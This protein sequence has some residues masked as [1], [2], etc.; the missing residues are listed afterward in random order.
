M[1]PYAVTTRTRA[2]ATKTVRLLTIS[3]A[4]AAALMVSG[5]ASSKRSVGTHG[6]A[7]A[8]YYA[9]G[10][11]DARRAVDYWGRAYESNPK[12]REAVLNYA[13][14][15][16]R[17]DQLPQ[18]EAVLRKAVINDGRDRDIASAYGKTLA[19][20]GKLDESLQ[21]IRGAQSPTRPDWRLMSAEAAVID[22]M[23]DGQTA[24][25]LYAQALKIAPGEP[26]ILNNLGMSY[27]L[28]GDLNDAETVLRSA[29][30]SPKADS[31]IRQNLALVL[32]LQGKFGEAEQVARTEIDPAQADANIAYLKAMLAKRRAN[33]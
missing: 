24:R 32:G 27:L 23:G 22:Q 13:A 19:M 4:L 20:N 16:R 12:D 10:S 33:G 31:R 1:E 29:S 17:N 3:A 14:A 15:L 5:C 8:H 9:P 21:V 30:Q 11:Q 26:S 2:T 6:A 18:A 28:S 7:S 25:S